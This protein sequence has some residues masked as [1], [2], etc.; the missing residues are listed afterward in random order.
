M[1]RIFIFADINIK[2]ENMPPSTQSIKIIVLRMWRAF[3]DPFLH[4][5]IIRGAIQKGRLFS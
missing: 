1:V 3:G 4:F 5:A 2:Q